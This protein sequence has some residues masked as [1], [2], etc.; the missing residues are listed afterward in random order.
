M[1]KNPGIRK[2]RVNCETVYVGKQIIY[3]KVKMT[4]LDCSLYVILLFALIKYAKTSYFVPL[5][6]IG[7]VG[8]KAEKT[9]GTCNPHEKY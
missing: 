9:R 7:V 8:I 4:S 3:L 5:D 1:I 6:Y 2:V